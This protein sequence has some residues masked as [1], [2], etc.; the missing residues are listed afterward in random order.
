MPDATEPDATMHDATP[1]EAMVPEA[2]ALGVTSLEAP[3]L[4][5]ATIVVPARAVTTTAAD[6]QQETVVPIVATTADRPDPATPDRRIPETGVRLVRTTAAPRDRT[7]VA[8]HATTV[9]RRRTTAAHRRVADSATGG[10]TI[11]PI[12]TAVIAA[13]VVTEELRP[14]TDGRRIPI[15]HRT[16]IVPR[17][18]GA[19]TG[20]IV[21]GEATVLIARRANGHPAPR[22]MAP[23]LG[24][25]VPPAIVRVVIVPTVTVRAVT[26]R[27]GIVPIPTVRAASVR[28]GTVR[29]VTGPTV[30]A[31]AIVEPVRTVEALP[32]DVPSSGPIVRIAA[33]VTDRAAERRPDGAAIPI[34]VDVPTV[35]PPAIAV[36]DPSPTVAGA[37]IG[38]R[39]IGADARAG[40]TTASSGS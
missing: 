40:A 30:A 17:V 8:V 31:R 18:P 21:P 26:V 39:P 9:G 15:V 6:R 20:P 24:V 38:V 22:A 37:P 12:A 25:V 5:R 11:D 14:V 3:A 19:P 1:T 32:S 28:T 7:I 35:G 23:R 16:P 13:P 4:E 33:R 10:P 34:A 2:T 36:A 27:T 29:A